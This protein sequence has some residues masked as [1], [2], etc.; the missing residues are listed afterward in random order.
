[1]KCGICQTDQ[2]AV[3]GTGDQKNVELGKTTIRTARD[4]NNHKSVEHKEEREAARIR[5]RNKKQ[6]AEKTE[7]A[8]NQRRTNAMVAAGRETLGGGGWERGQYGLGFNQS[9]HLDNQN[10]IDGA[11][12]RGYASKGHRYPEPEIVGV[13]RDMLIKIEEMKVDAEEMLLRAWEAGTPVTQQELFEIKQIGDKAY[14]GEEES[15][16]GS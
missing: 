11:R 4:L 3:Y 10:T 12:I 15:E 8:R 1:M 9:N 6:E 16:N 2:M 14:Y 7:S 13:Y 5:A